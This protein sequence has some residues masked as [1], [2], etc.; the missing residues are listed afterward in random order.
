MYN[1]NE[2]E[3]RLL[4][5]LNNYGFNSKRKEDIK[6]DGYVLLRKSFIID[7]YHE[8]SYSYYEDLSVDK[9]HITVNQTNTI[10]EENDAINQISKL[11][12]C[13]LT[14]IGEK[15]N[16]SSLLQNQLLIVSQEKKKFELCEIT[17]IFNSWNIDPILKA[18]YVIPHMEINLQVYTIPI[19]VSLAQFEMN[20][21]KELNNLGLSTKKQSNFLG[22]LTKK[23]DSK[24]TVFFSSP[25][26]SSFSCMTENNIV[27]SI[28]L[29]FN[30]SRLSQSGREKHLNTMGKFYYACGLAVEKN[31]ASKLSDLFFTLQPVN[32]QHF[33]GSIYNFRNPP[34]VN[35][36]MW[37]N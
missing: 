37:I 24:E 20:I 16:D 15:L 13:V 10:I 34:T 18:A 26:F 17:S 8:I 29:I 5:L 33:H 11:L 31:N 35:C 27:K 25:N 4:L 7:G 22:S 21:K 36:K 3:N 23:K 1:V 32:I 12:L 19:A 2:F 28:E 6:N 14:A 30:C 9:I